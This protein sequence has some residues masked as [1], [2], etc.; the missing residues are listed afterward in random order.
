MDS[1]L[2]DGFRFAGSLLLDLPLF[3]PN[4]LSPS[5][6][7]AQLLD[8]C[9]LNL[10]RGGV[11]V[12]DVRSPQSVGLAC[13]EMGTSCSQQSVC[14]AIC[15]VGIAG[16]VICASWQFPGGRLTPCPQPPPTEC[17]MDSNLLGG[18]RFAGSLLLDLPLFNP[19]WLSPSKL[20]AQLLDSCLLNLI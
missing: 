2:Q 14:A 7:A 16:N 8:S 5:K 19:N 12:D 20:A 10:I 15:G 1:D 6:L 4:W 9:L 13:V 18:F 17:R 11:A 3:N